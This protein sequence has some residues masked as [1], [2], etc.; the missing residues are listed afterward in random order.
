MPWNLDI[1]LKAKVTD[2]VFSNMVFK[3]FISFESFSENI[4]FFKS[5]RRNALT[6]SIDTI[7]KPSTLLGLTEVRKYLKSE[8]SVFP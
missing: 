8:G 4:F 2:T 5:C 1:V 7:L 6:F 3:Y